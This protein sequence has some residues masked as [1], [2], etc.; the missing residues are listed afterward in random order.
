MHGCYAHGGVSAHSQRTIASGLRCTHTP[1]HAHP[2][3]CTHEPGSGLA[4]GHRRQRTAVGPLLA[5]DTT[6][7][8][9][10]LDDIVAAMAARRAAAK[11][12]RGRAWSDVEVRRRGLLAD[13]GRRFRR[14][15][16]SWA[17]AIRLAKRTLGRAARLRQQRKAREAETLRRYEQEMPQDALEVLRAVVARVRAR[18]RFACGGHGRLRC[19]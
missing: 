17:H 14:Q 1:A 10:T 11:E 9:A 13:A 7:E 18:Q 5:A 16:K 3:A 4:T 15:F 8:D 2:H 19:R 6:N 12:R